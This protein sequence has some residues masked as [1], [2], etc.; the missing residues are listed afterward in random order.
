[1]TKE[2]RS[3]AIDFHNAAIPLVQKDPTLAYRLLCSSVTVDPTL[4]PAWFMLGATCADLKALPAAIAALRRC[5]EL[6][7]GETD[8]DLNPEL[9][10]KAMV[11]LG[12][13]LMQNGDLREAEA[14]TEMAINILRAD[15]SLDQEGR[16]FAWT[17]MSLIKSLEGQVGEALTYAMMAFEMSQAAIIETGLGFAY[18]FAGDYERGLKHFERRFEYNG[19]FQNL[20]YPKWDGRK[21][22]TIFIAADAGMGDTISFTRF[23]TKAARRAKKVV[24]QVQSEILRMMTEAFAESR[25]IEVMPVESPLPNADAWVPIVSLPVVLGL[26]N[27]EIIEWKQKWKVPP[28]QE[29]SVEWKAPDRF[30]HVGIAY[31]GSPQNEID[32]WRSIP[33]VE[34]LK[35]YQVPGIQLYS[36]QVGDRARDLGD[37][38]TPGIIRDMSPWIRDATDTATIIRKLDLVITIDSFLGHLCGAMGARCWVLAAKLGGDWRLGRH[39]D[40]PLWYP[41][42]RIFRQGK[43]ATWAPVFDEVVEALRGMVWNA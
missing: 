34:F 21:V 8:G 27:S 10:A 36:L 32:R 39:G 18:L 40:V 26:S 2:A 43:D 9:R 1:M 11:N 24:W 38:Y 41:N 13:R 3:R 33:I 7:F 15:P 19:T 30:I 25:N 12:H 22:D 37:A 28:S 5:L 42:T 23:V 29:A 20:P 31:G 16:A 6:P 35:L 4:A 17:N 14:I